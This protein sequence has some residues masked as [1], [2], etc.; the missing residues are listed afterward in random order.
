MSAESS[1]EPDFGTALRQSLTLTA[2]LSVF[3]LVLTPLL[4]EFGATNYGDAYFMP[5]WVWIASVAMIGGAALLARCLFRTPVRFPLQPVWAC[6]FAW[7]VLHPLSLIWSRSPSLAIE[8]TLI[9]GA[10]TACLWVGI[11]VFRTRRSLIGFAWLF[12][13]VATATAAWTLAQDFQ[14]AFSSQGPQIIANLSD[15][16]GYLTAGLGNTNHIGDLLA[17]GLLITLVLFGESRRK[18]AVAAALAAAVLI[19]AALTVCYSVGSN[20]GLVIGAATFFVILFV[21]PETHFFRRHPRR[22]ILLFSLWAAMI[23][24]F[25][26][27]H[28]ANPHRPGI[29]K[30]GFGSERWIEGWDTRLVIWAGG[31]ELVR[32]HPW[33]GVGAGNFTYAYP[34]TA[35]PLLDGH[36]ELLV[37][38]GHW[39]NAAHNMVLQVW[40]ELGILGLL[41]FGA[42]IATAYHSLLA[43]IRWA[44]RPEFMVRMTLTGLWCALLGHSIMNFTLQQPSGAVSFYLLLLFT[45]VERSTR[46]DSPSMPSLVVAEGWMRLQVDW[47]TMRRPTAVGLALDPPMPIR[48]FALMALA[49]M[50]PVGLV[51]VHRGVRAEVEYGRAGAS[52]VAGDATGEELHMARA[53]QLNPWATGCRSRYVEFLLERERPEEALAQLELVRKRLNSRELWQREARALG[54]LGRT[55]EAEEKYQVYLSRLPP[56]AGG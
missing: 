46:G 4:V 18:V 9:V 15:W 27:D 10:L 33:L 6:A 45:V 52:R 39:T 25:V 49:A 17:L 55:A 56:S 47:E 42:M 36:P 26:A 48:A 37:Y 31:L 2:K 24:F 11:Q 35:S 29:L 51:T 44:P 43:G 13:A 16:R 54:L 50:V 5:K 20:L 38:R 19:A 32:E 22:W 12:V 7:F 23:A 1:G 14:Q 53:L 30:Q 40:S 41:A 28:P 34:E 3:A 21:R 8:R